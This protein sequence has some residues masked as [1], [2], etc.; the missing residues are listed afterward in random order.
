MTPSD[1]KSLA[2]ETL[3]L[4]A[5]TLPTVI[6]AREVPMFEV[7]FA[8]LEF[9]EDVQL[10]A[11]DWAVLS[12]ARALG[13]VTPADVDGYLGLGETVSEGIVH[14]LQHDGLLHPIEATT[15]GDGAEAG[16][17]ILGFFDRLFR[18]SPP[19]AVAHPRT[20]TAARP[21]SASRA[22]TSPS[23]SLTAGGAAA[24]ER[25]AIAQRRVRPG[26]LQFLADPLLYVGTVD[27]RAHRYAQYRR[28]P[29]LDPDEVPAPFRVLDR[30]LGRQ[31]QER[32]A[33]CGILEGLEGFGGRFVGVVPGSQWEVRPVHGRRERGALERRTALLLAAAF[34]SS[35]LEG[36][37]WRIYVRPFG[38]LQDCPTLEPAK[39]PDGAVSS[40]VELFASMAAA[41]FDFSG[42]CAHR[43]DGAYEF[44]F[45]AGDLARCLG[46]GDAP[47]DVYLHGTASGW[48]VGLRVHAEPKGLGAAREAFFEF[49]RRNDPNLRRD[50]DATCT[51][52]AAG[53]LSYW[54]E[55]PELPTPD[56]AA[57]HLWSDPQLRAALC[58]RRVQTDLELA[59]TEDAK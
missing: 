48:T 46:D 24:L 39:L 54:R 56:D 52:V 10:P 16:G 13:R 57:R 53:L 41:G 42:L 55:P 33:A 21:L 36:L 59:Y 25:G 15:E 5:P 3:A 30:E 38:R 47:E 19:V 17:G 22:P 29:P 26:R 14:R 32:V 1:L 27:E 9:A 28:P 34:P 50:F 45:D 58:A 20:P 37:R 8:E 4:G 31:P 12:L 35:D 6:L 43:P 23:L 18:T 7:E 51:R 2:I 40:T 11:C 44:R 49:L